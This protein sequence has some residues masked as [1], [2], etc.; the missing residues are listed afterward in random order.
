MKWNYRKVRLRRVEDNILLA[1]WILPEGSSFSWFP[2]PGRA[3]QGT[4]QIWVD[5]G[6]GPE[7]MG[8]PFRYDY[9]PIEVSVAAEPMTG[10]G[11][12]GVV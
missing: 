8:T 6:D 10:I 9:R 7:R 12:V 1:E 2:L 5:D 4:L 11:M 3:P